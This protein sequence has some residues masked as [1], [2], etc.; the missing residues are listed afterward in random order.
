MPLLLTQ[1]DLRPLV[2]DSRSFAD[3]FRVIQ[4]SLLQRQGDDLGYLSWLAFPLGQK[5]RRFNTNVLTTPIDGTSVRI[6]PISGGDIH[7]A[8][9]GY[10]ALLIDNE[11]GH[12][13]AIMATDDLSP[14][15]TSAPVGLACTHLARPGA[16]TLAMI[17]SGIQARYHLRAIS[18]GVPTLQTVRVFSPTPEHRRQYA[19]EMSRETRLDIEAVASAQK[20]VEHADIICIAANSR[21]P[22]MDANWVQPGALV[23]SITGQGLPHDL[24]KRVVVPAAAG[25]VVLPSG[26]DPR[27]IMKAGGG[28]DHLTIG[29]TLADVIRETAPARLHADDIVVYE[30]RGSYAWDAALL[31]WAYNWA[32]EHRVGTNFQLTSTPN[33]KGA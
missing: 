7:P 6:F 11:D 27:P 33:T 26:W 21:K 13:Q 25:P 14:L 19:T 17:G 18:H 9:D 31:R 3:I 24:I 22:L 28:R 1:A 30:Q 10:V 4:D 20:A 8:G 15:R 29:A 32:L 5:E 12:L 2:E 23:V 16:T